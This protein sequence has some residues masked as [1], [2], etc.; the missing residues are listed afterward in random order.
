MAMGLLYGLYDIVKC[1]CYMVLR[2]NGYFMAGVD[3]WPAQ[4]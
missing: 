2:S 4:L 3:L 1:V